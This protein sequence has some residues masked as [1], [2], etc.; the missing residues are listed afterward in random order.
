MA[1]KIFPD[2]P[3]YRIE[4]ELG[5]GGMAT[6]HLAHDE[7]LDRKVAVKIMVLS[8]TQ[9]RNLADRFIREAK[10]AARLLH[11][12]IVSIYDVGFDQEAYYMVMEY[13]PGGN[14][15]EKLKTGI[16]DG[17]ETFLILKQMASALE[18]AHNQGFVHRDIKPENIL[19]RS[20]GTA[21]LTDFGIAR[22]VGS[23]T[24]LT[25]TGMSIG[26]PHYMSPEQARGR[27]LDGRADIYSLGVVFYEMLT[28]DVPYEAEDSVAVAIKHIQEPIPTL[29]GHLS[30]Y[31]PLLNRMMAKDPSDRVPSGAELVG[32]IDEVRAGGDISPPHVKTKPARG[33]RP[34]GRPAQRKSPARPADKD[35][36]KPTSAKKPASSSN[37]P[38]LM[39]LLALLV[40]SAGLFVVLTKNGRDSG[41]GGTPGVVD[42]PTTTSGG[43]P[44]TKPEQEVSSGQEAEKERKFQNYLAQAKKYYESG[45]LEQAKRNIDLAGEIK[46]TTALT[47]LEQRIEAALQQQAEAARQ[48]QAEAD[49]QR[50]VQADEAAWGIATSAGNIQAY[51]NYIA[52][53]PS[54]R[55]IAEARQRLKVL[56]EPRPGQVWRE[57]V[58]GM[59][60]VW[61]PAGEFQMGS[62]TGYDDEKPVHRVALDGF[63]MGRYEVTQ[64]EWK[65]ILSSNPSH[66]QSGDKYPIEEASWDDAHK[67][68]GRLNS[69]S[70]QRFRLP[71]EA[72]WE[73]ACRAGTTGDRYGDLEDIAWYAGNSGGKTHP[74]GQKRP[75]AWGLYDMLGNVWEW[76]S[77]RHET[78]A[79][80]FGRNPFAPSSGSFRVGRGG[81]WYDYARNVRSADRNGGRPSGRNSCLGFRLVRDK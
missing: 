74:V 65:K 68:I 25:R 58:T 1:E 40:V 50:E 26:T 27:E 76:C 49:R 77:D 79:S 4:H 10:T 12:N 66:F 59:E 57:P 56:A 72:E 28:G 53:Y 24:R 54:G 3:N 31:Q 34:S 36:P 55:H 18:F 46:T 64:G 48:R 44:T 16:T 7:K 17:A 37:R 45:D 67:F 20:D 41:A 47:G 29:P 11:S 23:T 69:R 13:L 52:E 62:N 42:Q 38:L 73:Y 63:W 35:R 81:S 5:T 39:L 9:D 19:F 61:I 15:R 71:T 32:L 21:V 33:D 14:L 75:N 6:V 70:G 78:Y 8:P 43:Q 30:R 51:Q 60:F 2:I 22:A 80:G